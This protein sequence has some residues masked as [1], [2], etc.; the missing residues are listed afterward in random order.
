VLDSKLVMFPSGHA[1]NSSANLNDILTHKFKL[2]AKLSLDE[3]DA[4]R[5]LDKL[6]NLGNLSNA[7]LQTI[8]SGKINYHNHS[9]DDK[10]YKAKL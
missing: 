9:I 2:L 5:V 3:K 7:E 10:D 8:Y 6:S 1:R 4:S